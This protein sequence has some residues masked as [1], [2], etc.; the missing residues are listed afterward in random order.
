MDSLVFLTAVLQG[1][2]SIT[3]SQLIWH[4][5]NQRSVC[6]LVIYVDKV[7][8]FVYIRFFIVF[9]RGNR[10]KRSADVDIKVLIY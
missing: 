6:Q 1:P 10:R 5:L 7:A 4:F 3:F 2:K 8:L 9:C